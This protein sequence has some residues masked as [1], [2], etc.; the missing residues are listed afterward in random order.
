MRQAL[1]DA[2]VRSLLLTSGTLSPLTSF[3]VELGTP[4]AQRLENPHVIKPSQIM[5]G[6]FP[7]GPAGTELTSTFRSRELPAYQADL[8][9]ALVNFARSVPQGVLVFFPSYSALVAAQK[10]W[11]AAPVSTVEVAPPHPERGSFVVQAQPHHARVQLTR[12]T[13]HQQSLSNH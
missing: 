13:D 10:A 11:E 1:E 9:N 3:A 5:V 12:T 7:R 8:G 2:G 6:V 4:F